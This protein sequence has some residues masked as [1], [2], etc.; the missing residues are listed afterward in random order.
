MSLS[1]DLKWRGGWEGTKEKGW[2]GDP[3]N[4]GHWQSLYLAV[5]TC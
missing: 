2:Y 3:Q 4:A 1:A 5:T